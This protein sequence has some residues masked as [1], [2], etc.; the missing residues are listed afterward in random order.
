MSFA[1]LHSHSGTPA[2]FSCLPYPSG[3]RERADGAPG[4]VIK[5]AQASHGSKGCREV[6]RGKGTCS[7]GAG[8]ISK[9][10]FENQPKRFTAATKCLAPTCHLQGPQ[11]WRSACCTERRRCRQLHHTAFYTDLEG[12]ESLRLEG[13]AGFW[14]ADRELS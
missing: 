2:L 4:G 9:L 14:E 8:S 12:Q 6:E 10:D 13:P 11:G 5:A 7:H 1:S 3:V